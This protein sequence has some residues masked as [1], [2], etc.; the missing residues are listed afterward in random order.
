MEVRTT[1]LGRNISIMRCARNL[2]S[3][4][5]HISSY[6]WSTKTGT[7]LECCALEFY[8]FSE[9]LKYIA[10]KIK[11]G[12]NLEKRVLLSEGT[13]TAVTLLFAHTTWR[14]IT[15]YCTLPDT[16]LGRIL[17][18][19]LKHHRGETHSPPKQHRKESNSQW[20]QQQRE[21]FSLQ[22]QPRGEF[23]SS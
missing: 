11:K 20:I 4:Y 5:Y 6:S 1:P 21:P 17:Y 13:T 7:Q 19:T 18:S 12:N 16:T 23:L 22:I 9:I 2:E 8:C 15:V 10:N 14:W 3:L